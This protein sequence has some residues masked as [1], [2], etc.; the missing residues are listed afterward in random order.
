V[1]SLAGPRR[2]HSRRIPQ[3]VAVVRHR[4]VRRTADVATC[5]VDDDGGMTRSRR[6]RHMGNLSF[7]IVVNVV[8]AAVAI[9]ALQLWAEWCERR[10]R[11]R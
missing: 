5:C 7:F 9:P 8:H 4:G 10:N 3:D 1:T 11:A 6:N 2:A